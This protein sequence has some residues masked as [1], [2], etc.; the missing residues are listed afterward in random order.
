MQALSQSDVKNF[1]KL[2][3]CGPFRLLSGD[4]T[5]VALK[6]FKK[7]KFNFFLAN[8]IL[9]RV[10]FGYKAFS[11]KRWGKGRWQKG[12][13][14]VSSE[15][16]ELA[17]NPVILDKIESVIGSDILLWGAIFIEK[18]GIGEHGWHADAEGTA[19]RALTVFLNLETVDEPSPFLMITGSQKFPMHPKEL[20]N[21]IGLNIRNDKDVLTMAKEIKG[22]CEYTKI[23]VKPGEFIMFDGSIWHNIRSNSPTTRRSMVLQ[24]CAPTEEVRLPLNGSYDY[25]FQWDNRI[26][27]P[28]ILVR[29]QDQ[30]GRNEIV[31]PK[32]I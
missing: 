1:D 6:R 9:S 10:P 11:R 22:D 29:G 25:P 26:S 21:K 23:H 15:I 20:E 19:W 24:Y 30:Y 17:S 13:H 2:G 8:R 14:I 7:Q 3:F 5:E 28:C 4:D 18:K 27:A 32:L 31:D 12:M 16:V